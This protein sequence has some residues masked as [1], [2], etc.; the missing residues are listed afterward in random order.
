MALLPPRF[1]YG[2]RKGLEYL[3]TPVRF[4]RRAL[5][6]LGQIVRARFPSSYNPTEKD[7]DRLLCRIPTFYGCL[8]TTQEFHFKM[9]RVFSYKASALIYDVQ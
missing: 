3:K 7:L 8:E 2:T 9:E 1:R 5:S 4:Q 6:A